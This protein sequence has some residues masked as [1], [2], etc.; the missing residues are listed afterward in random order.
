MLYQL[1]VPKWYRTIRCSRPEEFRGGTEVGLI[2]LMNI[3]RCVSS[4]QGSQIAGATVRV[5]ILGLTVPKLVHVWVEDIPVIQKHNVH[6]HRMFGLPPDSKGEPRSTLSTMAQVFSAHFHRVFGVPL[7]SRGEPRSTEAIMALVFSAPNLTK[8]YLSIDASWQSTD[9]LLNNKRKP[10][11][12]LFLTTLD[13]TSPSQPPRRPSMDVNIQNLNGLLHNTPNL[14]ELSIDGGYGGSQL[15]ACLPQLRK[16]NLYV[17]EVCA[18]GFRRL[19]CGSPRLAEVLVYRRVL[20]PAHYMVLPI[21]P[22]QVVDALAPARLALRRLVLHTWMPED[23][24][25]VLRPGQAFPLLKNLRLA[26]LFPALTQLVLDFRSVKGLGDVLA[27]MESL[28]G[29]VLTRVKRS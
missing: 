16:L 12:L 24:G 23:G 21:S 26:E 9:F 5:M 18:E 13:I 8:L 15:T 17:T 6:F 29:L 25:F 3:L 1:L 27:G 11:S 22:W 2:N 28:E 7:Y 4:L 19:V 10:V 20:C 14:T